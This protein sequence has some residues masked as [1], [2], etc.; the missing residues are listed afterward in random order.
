MQCF[1]PCSCFYYFSMRLLFFRVIFLP[2]LVFLSFSF[3]VCVFFLVTYCLVQHGPCSGVVL[4]RSAWCPGIAALC[5]VSRRFSAWPES[6][7]LRV[8]TRWS[9]RESCISFSS[10]S[11]ASPL[12]A[13]RNNRLIHHWPCS[14]WGGPDGS[15]CTGG[16]IICQLHQLGP[17]LCG[18]PHRQPSP[19]TPRM[20]LV[21]EK[22][23]FKNFI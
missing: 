22:N 11:T 10:C 18:P 9:L 8:C 23:L 17:P 13:Y 21:R 4:Q 5:L 7:S 6:V 19:R 12:E 14:S 2:L 1:S 15:I 3:P 16:R 20:G